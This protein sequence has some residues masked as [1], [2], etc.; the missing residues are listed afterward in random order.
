[1]NPRP[2]TLHLLATLALACAGAGIATPAHADLPPG[3][4][5]TPPKITVTIPPSPWE[6]WYPGPVNVTISATDAAGIEGLSYTLT[7]AQTGGDNSDFEPLDLTISEQGTTTINITATDANG[8]QTKQ[9]YG[10]GVDLTDPTLTVGGTLTDGADL[11]TGDVRT[12]EFTCADAPTGIGSCT[13]VNDG[14]SLPSGAAVSTAWIGRHTV[15]VTSTDRV[16]RTRVRTMAYWVDQPPLTIVS[17]PVIEGSPTTAYVGQLLRVGGAAFAPTPG[18]FMY[19]WLVDGVFVAQG[20]TYMPRENELGKRISV[21]AFGTL[22]DGYR[23]T[24]TPAVG[25]LLIELGPLRVTRQPTIEGNPGAVWPGE[26]LRVSGGT[27][28]PAASSIAYRW[29]AGDELVGTGATY[30]ARPADVGRTIAVEAVGTRAGHPDTPSGRVGSILVLNHEFGVESGPAVSGTPRVG[31]ELV[32]AGARVTPDPEVVRSFWTI[33]TTVTETATPRLLITQEHAGRTITCHQVVS[34]P[35]Y[36]DARLPCTFAGGADSVTVAAIP[37]PPSAGTDA[38]WSVLVA[39]A[40]RGKATV[41]KRL[42]AVLPQV[43]AP[44]QSWTYQWLRNG[45]PI[46]GATQATYRLRTK[47]AKRRIAL[48]ITA[49]S[50]TGTVLVSVSPSRKV[51]R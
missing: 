33:G 4:D 50:P 1:M 48:R 13:A 49:V 23:E 20:D 37:G 18:Y 6:G 10:V 8:L 47:D 39:A 42:R 17:N 11:H 30:T 28:E 24:Y 40:V 35:G 5:N 34:K 32:M 51:R 16:G 19:E 38:A 31:E 27:F 46:K 45:K 26:Q 21:R 15:T 25:N 29:Y 44:A 41:G 14:A 7:G 22:T 9:K 3:G 43:S 2:R 36:A 12:V